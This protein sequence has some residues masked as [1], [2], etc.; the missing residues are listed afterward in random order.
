V[1]GISNIENGR[2]MIVCAVIDLERP[3]AILIA[4]SKSKRA[5]DFK[6]ARTLSS[7]L[8]GTA[9]FIF[10]GGFNRLCTRLSSTVAYNVNAAIVKRPVASLDNDCKSMPPGLINEK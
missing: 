6:R 8:R 3:R 10:R 2:R 4:E 5:F 7:F 9:G 1:A